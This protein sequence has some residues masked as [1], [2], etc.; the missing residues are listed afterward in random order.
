VAILTLALGIGANTAIFSVVNAVLLEGLPYK[1]PRRLVFVWSTMISQGVPISGASA[2]DFRSWREQNHAFT[3][4][5]ASVRASFN[6][7][8]QGQEPAR[9]DG[10]EVTAEMFSVL[11]VNPILGRNFLAGD[12][13]WGQH[14]VVL[15]SYGLWQDK[16]GRDP[17]VVNRTMRLDGQEYTIVGVMPR[18]MPFFDDLPQPNL[19]V[20]LAYEE[21]TD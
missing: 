7:S 10:A 1:E 18:G 19:F 15:V 14:R 12:E 16:F 4:M 11:G 6:V 3:G 2:P 20:P 13:T 8:F 21:D 17:Q 5:A 9:L